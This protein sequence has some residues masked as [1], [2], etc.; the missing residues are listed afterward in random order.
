MLLAGLCA[1]CAATP[2][3]VAS[4]QAPDPMPGI[5]FASPLPDS[6]DRPLLLR[7][8]AHP[9][10][11]GEALADP[12]EWR[13]DTLAWVYQQAGWRMREYRET[14]DAEGRLAI[15]VDAQAMPVATPQPA[16][17]PEPDDLHRWP[18][19]ALRVIVD[20]GARRL[21]L[22]VD[23]DQVRSYPVS[24]GTPD[25]PTPLQTFTVEHIHHQPA[26]YPAPS[27]RRDHARRGEPLPPVVP[28]GPD[29]PL[30]D[31][32]VQLQDRI[33]IH[34]TNNPASIGLAASYGCIRM[35][36]ADIAELSAALRVGDRVK[37]TPSFV[38]DSSIQP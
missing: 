24:V 16:P 6:V 9:P 32:F 25:N 5:V 18:D 19:P 10:P 20:R 33:G 23:D 14:R 30:G 34:G 36:N 4:S 29:N 11:Q 35:H 7:V 1:G 28:P 26:W 2:Q 12:A 8:L 15:T 27:I 3:P 38:P 31:I 21:Y 13:F 17:S 37:V 22:R